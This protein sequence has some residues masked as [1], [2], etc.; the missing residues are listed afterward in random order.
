MITNEEEPE[1]ADQ[2]VQ[3]KVEPPSL[4]RNILLNAGGR[5][6]LTIFTLATTPVL[7]HGL[8]TE[9]YGIYILAFTF[10]GVLSVLDLGLTPAVITLLSSAWYE[11]RRDDARAIV[12]TGL[13][14]FLGIGLLTALVVAPLV[15]WVVANLLNVPGPLRQDAQIALWISLL[16]FISNL[17]LSV[18]NAIPFALERYDITTIRTV[19]LTLVTVIATLIYVLT[20]GGLV[21]VMV[22]NLMS[23]LAG[24]ALFYFASRVL[25]PGIRLVPGYDKGV[26]R[27]L[28]KFSGFKFMGSFGGILAYQFDRVV[29]ANTSGLPAVAFYSIPVNILSRVVSVLSELVTP[30]FPRV[31]KYKDQ[32]DRILALMLR[33][34]KLM[35]LVAAPV[36]IALLTFADLILAFWIGGTEGQEVARE[37]WLVMVVLAIAY[38][39]QAITVVPAVICEGVGRPEINNGFAVASAIISVPL[40]LILLPI[41][42]IEGA[43]L[44]FLI[45]GLIQTTGI[46][47]FVC[48]N[49]I[50]TRVSE[51]VAK[52]YLGPIIAALAG[53]AAGY[54]SRPMVSSIWSLGI[55]L[56][57]VIVVYVAVIVVL[58]V[59]GPNDLVY[60]ARAVE[61]TPG[62]LPGRNGF[63]RWVARGDAQ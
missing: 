16:A 43:A 2:E 37:S 14:L 11:Q 34:S 9:L 62:W 53:G 31:S 56:L 10:S 36:M 40:V 49:L 5:A 27:Q 26:L 42:G 61:R 23:T 60:F 1:Q 21:G 38:F 52:A 35:A 15:P 41:Y 3:K 48:R 33:G 17:C 54:F 4:L 19:G 50:H 28:A 12:G 25:L 47:L 44:A 63:L 6:L 59:V 24:L 45:N 51:L 20:G 39:I 55:A 30:L 58:R 7:L 32:E 57:F 18:F 29:I 8:G 46:I 13:T 22:I